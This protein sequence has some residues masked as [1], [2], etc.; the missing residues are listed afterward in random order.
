M[1]FNTL[2]FTPYARAK[3]L[4]MLHATRTEVGGFGVGHP[5]DPLLIIDIAL[6][7]QYVNEVHTR[8]DK[9]S[10]D[11]YLALYADPDGEYGF[12]ME[13]LTRVWIHTH[14]DGG[15]EPS[16]DDEATFKA[17]NQHLP[18]MI[19]YIIDEGGEE[20]CRARFNNGEFGADVHLETAV[21]WDCDFPAVQRN[22]WEEEL[23]SVLFPLELPTFRGGLDRRTVGGIPCTSIVKTVDNGV[24]SE[25]ALV[26]T[27]VSTP[28][29]TIGRGWGDDWSPIP[30]VDDDD[31]NYWAGLGYGYSNHKI[32]T[33]NADIRFDKLDAFYHRPYLAKCL[34]KARLKPKDLAPSDAQALEQIG[35][36]VRPE[37]NGHGCLMF[38]YWAV[39]PEEEFED[40][41]KLQLLL[42]GNSQKIVFAS[43]GHVDRRLDMDDETTKE[44]R[45][46]ERVLKDRA[47]RRKPLTSIKYYDIGGNAIETLS[48]YTLMDGSNRWVSVDELEFLDEVV[49]GLATIAPNQSVVGAYKEWFTTWNT[50][51]TGDTE[52]HDTPSDTM[53]QEV[54]DKL[55]A[56]LAACIDEGVNTDEMED[57]LQTYAMSIENDDDATD[58]LDQLMH[59]VRVNG[60]D[61][62]CLELT[63]SS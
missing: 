55:K 24:S 30:G 59:I 32:S 50:S 39:H 62:D 61:P 26:N 23:K 21:E 10:V 41:P 34:L 53:A 9:A 31:S 60:Y 37:L 25:S 45:S 2:R 35:I 46:I 17:H 43:T 58:I 38:E 40:D 52:D 19:M 18:W 42:T 54:L 15:A 63:P 13:C 51:L 56:V 28:A 8:F 44:L 47:K 49:A 1:D 57:R 16:R 7:K 4:H 14:P 12:P 36:V 3:L 33:P 5:K 29:S 22:L 27:P 20:Y 11:D 48:P 6:P